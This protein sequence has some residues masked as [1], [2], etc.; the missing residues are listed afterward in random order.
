MGAGVIAA[1]KSALKAVYGAVPMKRHLFTPL[2]RL[3][4]PSWLYRHLHFSGE[5]WI[6]L[7]GGRGFR[8][9]CLG[10][11]LEND[12]FW[13]GFGGRGWEGVTQEL[14]LR[15]AADARVIFD[16]GA[17]SGA[18]ALAAQACNPGARVHAFEPVSRVHHWLVTNTALNGGRVQCENCAVSDRTGT[19]LIY[20]TE[21]DI[22]CSASLEADML[23][24]VA[25][26]QYEVATI[27]IDGYCREQGIPGPNLVKIDVEK[28][29]AA[30]LRGMRETVRRSRPIMVIEVLDRALG[31]ACIAELAGL[32]YRVF[33]IADTAPRRGLV[34]VAVPDGRENNALFIPAEQCSRYG[35][36]GSA[37]A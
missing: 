16:I 8:M 7:P 34:P 24:A 15:L 27:D 9:T 17:N 13:S 14:W 18:Y 11:R 2:R 3:P 36:P 1:G 22:V 31:E 35:L 26:V 25:S 6:P 21:D 4:L 37:P 20:D 5:V 10:H 23:G 30:V 28:H 12:L 32:D 29:E 33:V 19:A